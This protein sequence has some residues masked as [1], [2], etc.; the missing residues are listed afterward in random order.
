M[1]D[2]VDFV[3]A[4]DGLVRRFDSSPALWYEGSDLNFAQL[5]RAVTERAEQLSL[6]GVRP[7]DHVGI[8]MRNCPDFVYSFFAIAKLKAVAVLFNTRLSGAD[9]AYQMKHSDITTLLLSHYAGPHDLFDE[10]R[11][12]MPQLSRADLGD[13]SGSELPKLR[14]IVTT[15][16]DAQDVRSL[17]A[18]QPFSDFSSPAASDGQWRD[19]CA[20]S[21]PMSAVVLL[22]SSGTTSRPKGVIL[23]PN[24]WRKAFDGGAR[25][26]FDQG[27][28]VLVCVPLFGILGLLNGL[29]T[30]LARGGK[31]V[32]QDGFDPKRVAEAVVN[33]EC[34]AMHVLPP[35]IDP[36]AEALRDAQCP[37]G[38]LTKGVVLAHGEDWI[39]KV[40]DDLGMHSVVSSYGLTE[41]LGP[42][43]RTWHSEPFETR[44]VCQG[45]ALPGVDIKIVD[46]A[47]GEE[48]PQG[49]TGEILIGGYSR[50]VGYYKD[51]DATSASGVSHGWLHSE[52][53]GHIDES[54]QLHFTGRKKDIYKWKGFNVSCAEVE[55]VLRN[56]PGIID[57]AVTGIRKGVDG[58]EGAAFYTS[59]ADIDARIFEYARANL[60]K[61]KVPR[62]VV[63]VAE[64]P[65]TAGTGKIIKSRLAAQMDTTR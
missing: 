30:T 5:G 18:I 42:I 8:W 28:R 33:E 19:V 63:R 16:E 2:N 59:D 9:I 10:L 26:G 40:A 50:M 47:T 53:L 35:M 64:F 14:R 23:G 61:F 12:L 29:L 15:N 22:Y 65:R 41:S 39:R 37:A 36:L 43:A 54:G 38:Q 31:L 27:E 49:A 62:H 52:D 34:S 46:P 20:P 44:V 45:K 17:K 21:D 11:N 6:A 3:E 32:L 13:T 4:F 25:L 55:R 48:L 7:G 51:P 58:E 1:F 24:L 57:I 60:S 56:C